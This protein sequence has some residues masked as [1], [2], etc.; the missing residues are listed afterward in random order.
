M[1]ET[2]LTYEIV[3]PMDDDLD[4]YKF[5]GFADTLPCNMSY[6]DSMSAYVF[7]TT[8]ASSFSET[9][10]RLAYSCYDFEVNVGIENGYIRD[11]IAI[12]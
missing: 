12:M 9:V 5:E 7:N 8:R 4:M 2:H 11:N 10:Q 1:R 3:V 6:D